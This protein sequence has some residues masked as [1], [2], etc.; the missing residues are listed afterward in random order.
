MRRHAATALAIGVALGGCARSRPASPAEPP[1]PPV[2][3]AHRRAPSSA[4]WR[5][6]ATPADRFRLREWRT[7]WVTAFGRARQAGNGKAIAAQGVLFDPDQRLQGALPPAGDYRCRV[8]KVGANGTASGEFTAYP[9]FRCQV[10]REG[11]VQSLTKIGGSQRPVGLV[12]SDTPDRAIF[13]GTMMLGDETRPIDYG[14]DAGRDMI[15]A[16]ERVG[17]SRWRVV[18]PYPRYESILDVM[19]L[20]P[21]A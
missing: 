7:A 19:E 11:A 1:A 8:F 16:V 10:A 15:G 5:R 20:V 18:L 6:I 12:F 2:E 3:A 21:A 14:R 9:W 13:L 17:P 4:D